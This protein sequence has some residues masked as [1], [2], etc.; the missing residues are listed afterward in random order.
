M[1]SARFAYDGG[2]FLHRYE[3]A[4]FLGL[5]HEAPMRADEAEQPRAVATDHLTF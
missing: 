3:M 2:H 1:I 4:T 5:L